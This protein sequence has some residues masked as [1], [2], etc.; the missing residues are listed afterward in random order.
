MYIGANAQGVNSQTFAYARNP[1]C[2]VCQ[3]PIFL[4]DLDMATTLGQLL[5]QLTE[6]HA[7]HSPS[8]SLNGTFLYLANTHEEHK[9]KL[10]EV[11]H[12]QTRRGEGSACF[13]CV[14]LRPFCDC[15]CC[16]CGCSA[17]A[18]CW[19]TAACSS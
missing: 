8:V 10:E 15:A 3:P 2:P 9:D 19:R 14:L 13:G 17:L 11:T 16:G 1:A 5:T 4:K 18:R 12:T 6:Q 7:L